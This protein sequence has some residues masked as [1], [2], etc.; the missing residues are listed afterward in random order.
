M[1][2]RSLSDNPPAGRRNCRPGSSIRWRRGAVLRCGLLG[3]DDRPLGIDAHTSVRQDTAQIGGGKLT[4]PILGLGGET[5][6]A[7]G[8]SAEKESSIAGPGR[9]YIL[10]G[11]LITA[12]HI[13]ND[14]LDALIQRMIFSER[15][16]EHAIGNVMGVWGLPLGEQTRRRGGE[17]NTRQKD[18]S[19]RLRT[20]RS[21]LRGSGDADQR[22]HEHR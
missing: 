12:D 7:V 19:G 20:A 5:V 11:L 1:R 2:R 22:A 16:A 9:G 4:V 8:R 14:F 6:P 10:I 3:V 18:V 13:Q 21:R 17:E 15:Q